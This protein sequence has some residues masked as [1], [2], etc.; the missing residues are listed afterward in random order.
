MVEEGCKE[1]RG[2]LD[3]HSLFT[4]KLGRGG[5]PP[6][7]TS[8]DLRVGNLMINHYCSRTQVGLATHVNSVAVEPKESCVY[9]I[10]EWHKDRPGR[11]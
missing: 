1:W 8:Y 9:A 10:P 4:E 2:G 3:I 7:S 5:L 6:Y 11:S